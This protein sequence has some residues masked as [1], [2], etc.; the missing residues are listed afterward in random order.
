M[1]MIKTRNAAERE[2]LKFI[3]TRHRFTNQDVADNC[4][5]SDWVRINFLNSLRYDGFV[6]VCGK[7][8]NTK[9]FTAHSP[10]VAETI[11]EKVPG[12]TLTEATF[13]E[14]LGERPSKALDSTA[15]DITASLTEIGPCSDDEKEIWKFVSARDYF[16]FADIAN[17]CPVESVGRR[18]IQRLRRAGLLRDCGRKLGV[19]LMTVR[20]TIEIR[21]NA[22]D[23]RTT[24]EGA[25][26]SAIRQLR[27][28]R[29][30]DLFAALSPARQDISQ[31]FILEY[32]RTL[33]RASYLRTAS[34]TR[35]LMA[36]TPLVLIKNTGPLP[37]QK[38]SMTV[39]IDT[40]D[41]KIVY[42]PGGRLS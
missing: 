32:C 24:K 30:V 33:R 38:R 10:R 25:V 28:F 40:N 22:K 23:K 1:T 19:R 3:Q 21:E 4:G 31:D 27:R 41:D 6:T 5:A 34:R 14:Q 35:N 11:K 37:P 26:W 9:I 7:E 18:F 8:G 13:Q 20:K 36:E 2:I 12:R 17:V 29:P 16:S 42:A 15:V 39:V